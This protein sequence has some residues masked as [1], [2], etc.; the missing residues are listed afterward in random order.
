M[1]TEIDEVVGRAA[2]SGGCE[3]G[4]VDSSLSLGGILYFFQE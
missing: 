1:V 4:S 2:V 3:D